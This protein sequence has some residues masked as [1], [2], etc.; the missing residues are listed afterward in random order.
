MKIALIGDSHTEA[1]FPP[2]RQKLEEAGHQVVG[3]VSNR[4]WSVF[5]YNNKPQQIQAAIQGNPDVVVVS[6]GGNNAKLNAK[7]GEAVATFLQNI[8]YPQRRVV[9]VGAA[10]ALR[11]DV[12]TRHQW[13]ADW[14]SQNLP[15]D[16]VFIDTRPFTEV[17]HAPDGVHFTSSHYRDVWAEKIANQTLASIKLPLVLYK[18]KKNLPFILFVISLG[19]LSYALWRRY[20]QTDGKRP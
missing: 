9:W 14:L 10:K 4:G 1:Y 2:L 3:Q 19:G 7:Y 13:T 8:G 5:S 12:E 18:A 15:Q 20:G 17:G 6:L 16:I 11:Q